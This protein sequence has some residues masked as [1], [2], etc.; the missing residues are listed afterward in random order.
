MGV[1][2]Y[3]GFTW[4]YTTLFYKHGVKSR[5]I[6]VCVEQDRNPA[7]CAPTFEPQIAHVVLFNKATLA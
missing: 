6:A 5:E 3:N 2:N 4:K 1:G 7:E